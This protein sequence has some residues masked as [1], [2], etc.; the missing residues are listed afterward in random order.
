MEISFNNKLRQESR[1]INHDDVINENKSALVDSSIN[2]LEIFNQSVTDD[3]LYKSL[4]NLYHNIEHMQCDEINSFSRYFPFTQIFELIIDHENEDIQEILFYS[5]CLMIRG[6]NFE[7]DTIISSMNLLFLLLVLNHPKFSVCSFFFLSFLCQIKP[8]LGIVLC[9]QGLL[10]NFSKKPFDV[11]QSQFILILCLNVKKAEYQIQ[12]SSLIL[13]MFE[14]D[15]LL[16][17]DDALKSYLSLF[18][19]SNGNESVI[20]KVHQISVFLV[21]N[22]E[23]F[24]QLNDLNVV[25]DYLDIIANIKDLPDELIPYIFQLLNNE[26]LKIVRSSSNVFA[27][28]SSNWIEKVDVDLLYEILLSKFELDVSIDCERVIFTTLLKYGKVKHLILP[29]MISRLVKFLTFEKCSLICLNAILQVLTKSGI[30]AVD[31][32]GDLLTDVYSLVSEQFQNGSD[33]IFEVASQILI[34]LDQKNV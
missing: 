28:Q 22:F 16:I 8:N 15:S 29:Q 3:E 20:E 1:L 18:L 24:L 12:L 25:H 19:R 6:I 14:S 23:K 27:A 30:K 33:E 32:F 4:S 31:L 9:D 17:I 21:E 13:K 2:L 34:F 7:P 10:D 5:F 26:S 11:I